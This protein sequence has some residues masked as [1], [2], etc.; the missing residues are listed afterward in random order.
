MTLGR[1]DFSLI[2]NS[3]SLR[4][5]QC[6]DSDTPKLK[7]AVSVRSDFSVVVA[8]QDRIL[9]ADRNLWESLPR[10]CANVKTLEKILTSV[11]NFKVCIGNPDKDLQTLIPFGSYLDTNSGANYK[12]YRDGYL[13][14]TIRS[15]KCSG[16]S[17]GERCLSCQTYRRTLRK[18]L[19]RKQTS[20]VVATPTK[21]WLSSKT[22]NCKLTHSQKFHKLKQMR[23]YVSD[24][25]R[26][27]ERLK[28]EI[29][30]LIKKDG[31]SLSAEDS[32]DLLNVMNSSDIEEVYLDENA[33]QRLFWKEQLKYNDMADKRGMRWHPMIIKWCIF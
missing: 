14:S 25:E 26:E 6:Y 1:D 30:R 29:Q 21:N 13:D 17:T 8:V 10:T 11:A 16:L 4:L 27:N 2:R 32:A 3:E 31:V 9:P 33:Y 24:L 5:V 22:P 7:L 23:T 28:K 12:G 19:Q 20:E 18:L 15:A